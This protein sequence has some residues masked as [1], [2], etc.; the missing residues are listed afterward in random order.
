[1]VDFAPYCDR[2][3]FIPYILFPRLTSII[4]TDISGMIKHFIDKNS[5]SLIY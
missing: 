5:F 1:M 4:A 3:I 2:H